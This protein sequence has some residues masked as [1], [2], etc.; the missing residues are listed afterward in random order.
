MKNITLQLGKKITKKDLEKSGS[1]V[2]EWADDILKKVKFKKQKVDL[3]VKTVAEL[4]FPDGGTVKEIYTKAKEQGLKL[5][6]AE[7][8]P[9]LR[10][11]LKNQPIGEWLLIAMEPISGRRAHPSFFYVASDGDGQWLLA[12]YG[13]PADFWDAGLRF[14][15]VRPRKYPL[16]LDSLESLTPRI[17]SLEEFKN[18]VEKII[19]L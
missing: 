4:G 18:K 11:A 12:D 2:S 14:V 6:P 19:N 9:A 16:E 17:E 1:M 13:A 15:F 7:V 5:C 10:L 8:G 3:V